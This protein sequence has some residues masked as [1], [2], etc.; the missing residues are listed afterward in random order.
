MGYKPQQATF[1]DQFTA[2][3]YR[4]ELVT[5]AT[6]PEIKPPPA[7]GVTVTT[8][9][10]SEAAA[11][12]ARP[13][14]SSVRERVLEWIRSRGPDG[15]TDEECQLGLSMNPST[16]RPRRIELMRSGQ[17]REQ[18]TRPTKSGRAAAVWVAID[19]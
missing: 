6:P 14:S 12:A 19:E 3:D 18:G 2:G 5:N 17:I 16:Q 7:S 11:E 8:R 13:I 10:T 15:S 1:F 4:P 9:T